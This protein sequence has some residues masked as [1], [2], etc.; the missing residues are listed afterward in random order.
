MDELEGTGRGDSGYGSMGMNSTQT[1][2]IQEFKTSK[3]VRASIQI[4][5]RRSNQ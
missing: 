1:K 3:Q 5:K 4:E 2:N